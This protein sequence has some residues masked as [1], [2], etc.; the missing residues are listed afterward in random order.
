[1][2]TVTYPSQPKPQVIR[3]GASNAIYGLGVFGAWFYFF[4]HVTTLLQ[5]VIAFFQGIFWPAFMVFEVLK[6]LYKG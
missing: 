2:S 6:L 1:M 3:Y 5:G 4:S